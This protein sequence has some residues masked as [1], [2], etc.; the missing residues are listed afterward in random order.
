MSVPT[1]YLIFKMNILKKIF[2]LT[3]PICIITALI[4][5][6]G[7]SLGFLVGGLLSMAIFSLMYKYVLSMKGLPSSRRRIFIVPRSLIMYF[8]M[9]AAL[10]IGI[11]KGIPVFLG[12]LTGLLSLKAAIYIQVFQERHA[13]A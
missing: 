2:L 5:Y 6:K 7:F 12:T 11:K 3:G 13:G 1:E 8:L 9:G 10:F 4:G